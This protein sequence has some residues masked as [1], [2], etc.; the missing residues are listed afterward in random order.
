MN[1]VQEDLFSVVTR[2]SLADQIHD[3][4]L[5]MIIRNPANEE[6]VLN[7]KRLVEAFNVSKAPV[8]EA[9]VRLCSEGVVHSVPRFGYVVDR[10]SDEDEHIARMIRVQLETEALRSSFPRLGKQ[11]LDLLRKQFERAALKQNVDVWTVWQDNMEF[12]MLLA[13]FAESRVLNKFL[14]ES[15]DMQRRIYAQNYWDRTNHLDDSVNLAEHESI[16]KALAAGDLD[17]A[18]ECLEKDIN[19]TGK[20]AVHR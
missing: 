18:L 13:S 7:E 15:L 10:I 20:G 3:R 11:Q 17:K 8:R 4:I 2:D 16:L 19:I 6:Q 1:K 14:K 9:L 5:E 12:H